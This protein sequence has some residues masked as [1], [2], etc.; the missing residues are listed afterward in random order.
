MVLVGELMASYC[1]KRGEHGA[2]GEKLKEE[3]TNS[4]FSVVLRYEVGFFH[5]FRG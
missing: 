5:F 2:K 4:L 3:E 1:G